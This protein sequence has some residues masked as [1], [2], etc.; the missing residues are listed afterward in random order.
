M[1]EHQRGNKQSEIMRV[2]VV[3]NNSAVA[4][5]LKRFA[6][7]DQFHFFKRKVDVLFLCV[8]ACGGLHFTIASASLLMSDVLC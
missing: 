6:H 8:C 2:L 3:V 7:V 1:S 4:L 5:R